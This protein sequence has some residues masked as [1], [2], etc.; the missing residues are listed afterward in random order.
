MVGWNLSFQ[1]T[2][3][4]FIYSNGA[5][6]ALPNL[7]SCGNMCIGAQAIAINNSGFVIGVAN[8]QALADSHAA[9]ICDSNTAAWT[10]FG[11]GSDVSAINASGQVVGTGTRPFIY[12]NGITTAIPIAASAIN[13][14]GQ[15]VGG[16]YFYNGGIIDLNN[17]A[18]ASDPLKPFVTLTSAAGINDSLLIAVNGVDSRSQFAR[19]PRASALDH[20]FTGTLDVS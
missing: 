8:I 7:P 5:A 1:D 4:A 12:R 18:S 3:F 19:I 11:P 14:A 15:V 10:D 16:N 6:T 9:F 2:V 17:L 20:Y 13:T